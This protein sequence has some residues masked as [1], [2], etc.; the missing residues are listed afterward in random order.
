MREIQTNRNAT[1][2]QLSAPS[3]DGRLQLSQLLVHL[4][5]VGLG[6]GD[7]GA[8]AQRVA[9]PALVQLPRVAVHPYGDHLVLEVTLQV[10]LH[11]AVEAQ[12]L[13]HLRTML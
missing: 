2:L 8:L 4:S 6:L 9:A 1:G 7:G 13:D 3:L 12:L 5:Y 11:L 10:V